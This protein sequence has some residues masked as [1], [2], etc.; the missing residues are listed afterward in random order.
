[1]PENVLSY[2]IF[3]PFLGA[4]VLLLWPRPVGA[5]AKWL[6]IAITFGQMVL[7]TGLYLQFKKGPEAPA[8][9]YDLE[10]YQ[11][12]EK[13]SWFEISLGNAGHLSAEYLLGIDGL[14]VGLVLLATIVLFVGALASYTIAKFTK[15]YFALYLVLS[16]AIVGCFIALDFLLFYLFFEFMLLPMYFLIG[17]WGGSRREYAAVKFFIYTLV[18]S[19][20]ILVVMIGL[21][22]SVIDPAKTA[23]QAGLILSEAEASPEIIRKMQAALS[24]KKIAP[25]NLV[26]TFRMT[27]MMDPAN[28][29]PNALLHPSASGFALDFRFW[30]FWLLFIGFAI[31]LPIVPFH[32]WLPDAHVE[33]PTPISVVLAGILLKIGGYG[34]IRLAFP[35]FPEQAQ[36]GM[37]VMGFI[38]V[39][40]ILYGA[41]NALA[42]DDLKK[43]VA[44]S[45]VSHMGFVLLGLAALN[46]EG[47][48]GAI[49]QMWSHGILSALLFLLVGVLYDRTHSRLISHYRGLLG[50]M[51]Y[52]GFF[53]MIGFFASLGLP[54][55]S[56]FIGEL[57]TL[58][59]G[60]GSAGL[61]GW[62]VAGG[63]LGIVLGAAYF[64]WALQRMFFGKL[65][66]REASWRDK[67]QDLHPREWLVLS[68]L[69]LL[70]LVT[71][72]MPGLIFGAMSRSVEAWVQWIWS[73]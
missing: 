57:F 52:F 18:G 69:S 8:G 21:Y 42:M 31:K 49:Y 11:F 67:I 56:G 50:A 14:S 72:L 45:S 23:R 2:L 24:A 1:M 25:E 62:L 17:I 54:G 43:M 60:F 26:Y 20:L 58:L 39:F 34:M 22:L 63:V 35:I 5:W 71:G 28:F 6:T 61:P 16:G 10:G 36:A 32:T 19:L 15:G 65:W 4:L 53:V 70:T 44:H 46:S 7:A 37:L 13:A 47:V 51:P 64:L 12:V 48:H 29:A 66:L 40:S 73:T 38:G 33:A 3:L 68:L 30:A 55:F 9:V 27:A 41:L 59:G